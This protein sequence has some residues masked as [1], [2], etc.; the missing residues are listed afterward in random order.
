MKNTTSIVGT[1]LIIVVL[2][3]V[4]NIAIKDTNTTSYFNE[5]EKQESKCEYLFNAG[6][7]KEY[8]ECIGNGKTMIETFNPLVNW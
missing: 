2:L 8:T 7:G 4:A 3:A 6:K 1:G 5:V